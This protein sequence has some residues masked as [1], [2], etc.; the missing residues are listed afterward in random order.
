MLRETAVTTLRP[1]HSRIEACGGDRQGRLSFRSASFVSTTHD[2]QIYLLPQRTDDT[3][4]PPHM[5]SAV[6]LKAR[7]WRNLH[8]G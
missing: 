8:R 2:P 7:V 3:A 4:T 6:A 5:F 1:G